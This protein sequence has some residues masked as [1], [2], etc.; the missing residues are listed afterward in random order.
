MDARLVPSNGVVAARGWEGR[1]EATRFVDPDPRP[2]RAAVAEVRAAPEPGAARLTELVSG[3]VFDVLELRDGW[4]FGAVA[5]DGY[6]GWVEATGLAVAEGFE[7]THTIAVARTLLRSA[8]A[9]KSPDVPRP[10][11][12]GTRVA[13]LEETRDGSGVDWVRVR[14]A[15]EE[16][17]LPKAHLAPLEAR[18]DDPAEVASRFLGVPYLWGG[19]SG[20]GL[21]CSALT[22]LAWAAAGVAL[23]R[24]SDQQQAAVA[25]VAADDLRRGD[26]VFWKGHVG[27]LLDPGTLI[28]ANAHHMAVAVEPLAEAIERIG[29]REFGAVT[30]YGRPG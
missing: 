27:M 7:P 11:S 28:H 8:G 10:L 4:A 9:L 30:G 1:V 12:W 24:D 29:A 21:D 16:G 15:G 13:A 22:Q 26:L 6:A 23:P 19:R 18:S 14:T 2:C 20:F 3:E 17:W 5:A 25:P